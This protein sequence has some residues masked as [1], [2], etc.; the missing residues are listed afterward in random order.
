MSVQPYVTYR[1]DVDV[2][3]RRRRLLVHPQKAIHSQGSGISGDCTPFQDG[4]GSFRVVVLKLSPHTMIEPCFEVVY[5][6][7]E[8]R[9]WACNWQVRDTLVEFGQVAGMIGM[10]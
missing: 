2:E 6:N 4:I 7:D 5:S 8:L 1:F 3:I 10:Q 9:H